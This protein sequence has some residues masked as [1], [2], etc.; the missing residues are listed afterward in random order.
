MLI[1]GLTGGIA[2]GKSTASQEFQQLGI[3]VIDAD[4]VAHDIMR[5]GQTSFSLIVRNFGADILDKATGAIDR[6]KL[7]QIIFNDSGKRQLLNQCTHPYVRRRILWQLLRHYVRGHGICVLDVPLLFESGMDRMC[8]K[9]AVVTC[10]E[11]RQIERLME[12][13]AFNRDEA[14]ARVRAQMSMEEKTKRAHRVLDNNGSVEE[15]QRQVQELVK[16]WTPSRARTLVSMAA[17]VGIA[18]SLPF[19]LNSSVWGLGTLCTCV[20]WVVGSFFGF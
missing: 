3:P 19:A 1:V 5:P 16:D 18:V 8:G 4:T 11:A 2:T 9:V 12:R 6:N 14:V 13:N 15:T 7:G 20:A 17:P 10:T